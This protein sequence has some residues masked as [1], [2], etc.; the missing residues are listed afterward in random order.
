MAKMLRQRVLH[1]KWLL[2]MEP[3]KS[4]SNIHDAYSL[5]TKI[6]LSP[7]AFK[8]M[9]SKDFVYNFF[10]FIITKEKPTLNTEAGSK[11]ARHFI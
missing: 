1:L 2:Y 5:R 6:N 10:W 8:D 9:P 7:V 4:L 11:S 3:L